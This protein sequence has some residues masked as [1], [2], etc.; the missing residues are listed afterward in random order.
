MSQD[1]YLEE[2]YNIELQIR[3]KKRQI[4]KLEDKQ[5]DLRRE[6]EL[7]VNRGKSPIS[8]GQVREEYAN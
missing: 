7:W 6:R 2:L 4:A 1:P 5:K 3:E 8:M